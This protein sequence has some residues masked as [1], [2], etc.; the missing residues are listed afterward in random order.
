[1]GR[2]PETAPGLSGLAL[3]RGQLAVLVVVARLAPRQTGLHQLHADILDPD[4]ALIEYFAIGERVLAAVLTSD[5]ISIVPLTTTTRVRELLRLL[6]FQL[7]KFQY[8]TE[9]MAAVET[10]V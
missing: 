2:S 1:M 5:S 3:G 9:Y 8:G 7:S 10:G 4:A 6:Q